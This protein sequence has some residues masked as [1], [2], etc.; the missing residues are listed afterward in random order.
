MSTVNPKPLTVNHK[1]T[2]N[3]A[4]GSAASLCEEPLTLNQK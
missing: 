2:L 3:R 1:L 4:L